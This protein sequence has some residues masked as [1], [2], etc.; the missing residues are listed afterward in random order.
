[1]PWVT[2]ANSPRPERGAEGL[3][4]ALQE[5]LDPKADSVVGGAIC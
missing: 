2:G 1:M 3:V 5:I 4:Y